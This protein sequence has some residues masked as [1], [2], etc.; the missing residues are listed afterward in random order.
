MMIVTVNGRKLKVAMAAVLVII[1]CFSIY[2]YRMRAYQASVN[3]PLNLEIFNIDKGCVT[4][5]IPVDEDISAESKKIIKGISG[6][7]VKAN[8]I[9]E[10]GSIIKIPIMPELKVK[11]K[12]LNQ[13]GIKTI[14]KIYIVYPDEC[15][16]YLLI[17]DEKGRPFLYNC[18]HD[19]NR[20]LKKAGYEP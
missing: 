14:D 3:A 11:N 12:W 13:C 7:Y 6:L 16:P 18:D 15:K 9:P 20:L 1:L 5:V 8:A 10:K 2:H 19:I 4:K 17:L